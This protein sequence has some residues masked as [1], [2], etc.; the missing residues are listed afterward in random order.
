MKTVK[1]AEGGNQ[2]GK[3]FYYSAVSLQFFAI[4]EFE[5]KDKTNDK[6]NDNNTQ[7]NPSIC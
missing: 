5:Y 6:G 1:V 7:A 4:L 3:V 2:C